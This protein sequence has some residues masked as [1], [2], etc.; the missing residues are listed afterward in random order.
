MGFSWQEYQSELPFP[1]PGNL[2]DP[3]IKATSPMAST[4][5]VDSLPLSL[6]GSLGSCDRKD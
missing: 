2:P 3:G 5:Q 4:L 1:T 6:L